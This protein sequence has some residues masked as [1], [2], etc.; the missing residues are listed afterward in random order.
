MEGACYRQEF[1]IPLVG[2]FLKSMS[3]LKEQTSSVNWWK[4]RISFSNLAPPPETG[5]KKHSPGVEQ[6]SFQEKGSVCVGGTLKTY[7]RKCQ[8]QQSQLRRT[9]DDSGGEFLC[10]RNGEMW[11]SWLIYVDLLDFS[12]LVGG[13]HGLSFLFQNKVRR[14]KVWK[15]PAIKFAFG[16]R[17]LPI[18]G[19]CQWSI[20]D[21]IGATGGLSRIA[22]QQKERAKVSGC[23]EA[24]L[25]SGF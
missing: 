18:W 16:R 17:G 6:V 10:G 25:S 9:S 3:C 20:L 11:S 4:P 23:L 22:G 24:Q 21:F 1:E 19:F 15:T 13:F 14:G 2:G 12:N 7:P 8:L 5:T